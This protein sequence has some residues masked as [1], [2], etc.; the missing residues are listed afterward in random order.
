M[1]RVTNTASRPNA[2]RRLLD[3]EH[4]LWQACADVVARIHAFAGPAAPAADGRHLGRSGRGCLVM[5]SIRAGRSPC[6]R[7][8]DRPA[9]GARIR[10]RIADRRRTLRRV[11][12]RLDTACLPAITDGC[13]HSLGVRPHQPRP[14]RRAGRGQPRVRRT[15]R[16]CAAARRLTAPPLHVPV[17]RWFPAVR[18]SRG[19][20]RVGPLCHLAPAGAR[21]GLV[22]PEIDPSSR[23]DIETS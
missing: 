23:K 2:G 1:H 12:V 8:V 18:L 11:S 10:F 16:P 19:A 20:V 13:R 14:S 4:K 7:R 21:A 3:G 5:A 6:G 17:S 9:A 15:R 22:D